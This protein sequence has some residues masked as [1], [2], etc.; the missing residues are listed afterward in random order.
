[1]VSSSGSMHN[2]AK[3]AWD[4]VQAVMSDL[5][6]TFS[7]EDMQV[8]TEILDELNKLTEVTD[9]SESLDPSAE[10][11]RK[12]KALYNWMCD[13]LENNDR[14]ELIRKFSKYCLALRGEASLNEAER[15]QH[16]TMTSLTSKLIH[17]FND[18][19]SW[20]GSM[21]AHVE[22][23]LADSNVIAEKVDRP[24]EDNALAL[25]Q[26][27]QGSQSS[28]CD[29]FGWVVEV[30]DMLLSIQ[31]LGMHERLLLE[32]AKSRCD[33]L[34]EVCRIRG[35]EETG[36][37]EVILK[38]WSNV[39]TMNVT[40]QVAP[41]VAED[42]PCRAVQQM[43]EGLSKAC[44]KDFVIDFVRG[45]VATPESVTAIFHKS[46][47]DLQGSLP[48][49]VSPFRSS[50]AT[51]AGLKQWHAGIKT[52]KVVTTIECSKLLLNCASAS[53]P[54]STGKDFVE[55]HRVAVD[56]W[57]RTFNDLKALAD[58]A[59]VKM[60]LESYNELV[61]T[62]V[63]EWNFAKTPFLSHKVPD[64]ESELAFQES[65]VVSRTATTRVFNDLANFAPK[66]AFTWLTPEMHT[67]C[68]QVIEARDDIA[69][70]ATNVGK[71]LSMMY[72]ALTINLNTITR[73]TVDYC[74]KAFAPMK[75]LPPILLQKIEEAVSTT[76]EPKS[77]APTLLLD[78]ESELGASP[79]E[80]TT[81]TTGAK[82]SSSGTLPPK[83]KFKRA[84]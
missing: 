51:Y 69:E 37:P 45:V 70:A 62:A 28:P 15:H 68:C 18:I 49:D 2:N 67:E 40:L 65:F 84:T 44:V 83:K 72:L 58:V 25:S 80:P 12:A 82:S 61:L 24:P 17:I 38:L 73:R 50:Y 35:M 21:S 23:C 20:K 54:I 22:A 57:I 33:I 14:S 32:E 60:F 48:A 26:K 81:G 52:G 46:M 66:T 30:L 43:S 8:I 78:T 71:L 3:L 31:S 47:E 55:W 11:D 4:K 5:Q 7:D 42:H 63:Q 34:L 39:W 27:S 29:E 10:A 1:M 36:Q 59:R 77:R 76:G 64:M 6:T 53:P 56:E 74:A 75:E 79:P 19:V 16:D 13:L 41:T 9:V